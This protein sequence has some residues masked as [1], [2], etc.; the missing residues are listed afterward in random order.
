MKD[1][2]YVGYYHT[3]TDPDD[4]LLGSLVVKNGIVDS[5]KFQSDIT[6]TF[7]K[8]ISELSLNDEIVFVAFNLELDF[9]VDI[10]KFIIAIQHHCNSSK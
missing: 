7:L 6:N 10:S 2:K 9:I 1:G 4:K 5:I 3:K 8:L